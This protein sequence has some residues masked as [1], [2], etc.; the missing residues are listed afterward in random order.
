MTNAM[1]LAISEDK[2]IMMDYWEPSM[3]TEG[4]AVIGVKSDKIT[5][6][7]VKNESEYTSNISKA[8][9]ADNALII[10]TEN[11]IYMVSANIKAKPVSG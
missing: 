7:L 3:M 11:S 8:Y 1:K 10:L 2:P 5:K 6:M 4:G 9:K